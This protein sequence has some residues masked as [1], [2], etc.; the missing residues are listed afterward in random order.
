[1]TEAAQQRPLANKG[2]LALSITQFFGAAN[3]YLLKTMLV[4]A[5][6]SEGVWDGMLGNG[7]QVYPNY[8]LVLPFFLFCVI[9]GQMADRHSK[10]TVA[11]RVKQAEIG[12]ALLALAGFWLGNVWVCLAAMLMLGI[13]SAFFSPAKYGLIPE[14]VA[15]QQLSRANGIINLLTNLAAIVATVVGGFLYIAYVGG[16]DCSPWRRAAAVPNFFKHSHLREYDFRAHK[17]VTARF[18]EPMGPRQCARSILTGIHVS[19]YRQ[20]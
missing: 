6:A 18:V 2:F 16:G 8:S 9:A 14:L 20:I 7:G 4:F 1:M 11:V 15:P 10:R 19:P 12:F 17:F 13:Q 3:D 5:V